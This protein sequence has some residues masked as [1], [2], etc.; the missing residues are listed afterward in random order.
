MFFESYNFTSQ[1]YDSLSSFWE[2]EKCC[3][4]L[5]GS[6]RSTFALFL[7][8][9]NMILLIFLLLNLTYAIRYQTIQCSDDLLPEGKHGI[10]IQLAGQQYV[11]ETYYEVHSPR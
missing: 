10:R 11:H 8:S 1:T 3:I 5:L 6:F 2:Q 9:N 7:F 4:D